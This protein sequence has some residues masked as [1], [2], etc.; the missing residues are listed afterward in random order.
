MAKQI[1]TYNAQV[2]NYLRAGVLT[3]FEAAETIYAGDQVYLDGGGLLRRATDP[4]LVNT[5]GGICGVAEGAG[6]AGDDVLVWQSGVFEFTT[7]QTCAINPGNYV[8]V[9]GNATKVD[10]GGGNSNEISSGVAESNTAGSA[11]GEVVEVFITPV[12]KR[13]PYLYDSDTPYL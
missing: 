9:A 3:E 5:T 13:S 12:R 2:E 4:M 10:L 11:S 6:D 8:Y 1:M 7:N